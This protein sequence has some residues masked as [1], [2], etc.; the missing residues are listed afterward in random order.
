MEWHADIGNAMEARSV[1]EL[2]VALAR[3]HPCTTPHPLHEAVFRGEVGAT[4][5]LLAHKYDVSAVCAGL[6]SKGPVTPLQLLIFA[7]LDQFCATADAKRVTIAESL[8][9]AGSDPNLPV[10]HTGETLIHTVV[11]MQSEALLTTFLRHRAD[12]NSTDVSGKS[13]L[14]VACK[15]ASLELSPPR[16]PRRSNV[17]FA[18]SHLLEAGANPRTVSTYDDDPELND[19]LRK[20]EM[21]WRSRIVAWIRCR[22]TGTSVVQHLPD[23]LLR[24]VCAFM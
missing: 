17:S 4:D 15:C 12:P 9:R 23:D 6:G 10:A 19:L 13:V 21:W 16:C 1:P 14:S 11:A 24:R 3:K 22:G 7:P 20:A 2:L 5:Y 8:L 18:V